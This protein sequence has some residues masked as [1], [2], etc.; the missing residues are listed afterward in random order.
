[1]KVNITLERFIRSCCK[2]NITAS[3]Q[4][5]KWWIEWTFP[6]IYSSIGEDKIESTIDECLKE[7]L[8]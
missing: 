3:K 8:K 2:D 1:M 4:E 5:I 6:D 7:L